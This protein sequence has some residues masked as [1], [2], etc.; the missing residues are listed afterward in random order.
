MKRFLWAVGLAVGLTASSRAA[1]VY[2]D[3]THDVGGNT[4]VAPSAGGGV[5]NTSGALNSQGPAN[6][7][8]WDV[9]AF[10]NAATIYQNAGFGNVDN[11]HRLVTTVSVPTNTYN[12]YAYFWSDTSAWRMGASLTDDQGELPLYQYNPTTAGVVQYWTGSDGT[13]LSNVLAPNPFTTD[14]MIAE[15]NRRLFQIPLGQ[16]SGSSIS[17]FVDDDAMMADGNQRTWFDGI[18]YE[19]VPEPS[20][21]MLAGLALVGAAGRFRRR[22]LG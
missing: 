6:D 4:A 21:I 7:G 12:V 15:G 1:I 11:A 2:V 8:L 17:V 5:F 10:G 13:Q 3:A 14:V 9:R 16:V 18:G 19:P 20:T 22:M